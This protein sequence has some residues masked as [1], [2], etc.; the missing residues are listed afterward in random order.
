MQI[1]S[2]FDYHSSN[3][4]YYTWPYCKENLLVYSHQMLAYRKETYILNLKLIKQ[5]LT[6]ICFLFR[7]WWYI[8]CFCDPLKHHLFFLYNVAF[9]RHNHETSQE[10]QLLMSKGLIRIYNKFS[11][12]TWHCDYPYNYYIK[13]LII[14]V[15]HF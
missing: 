15:L 1:L 13:Y 2:Q 5:V 6:L 12:E 11:R 3:N 10:R 9:C 4:C 14:I 7:A 8:N